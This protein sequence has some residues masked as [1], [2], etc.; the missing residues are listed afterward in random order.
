MLCIGLGIKISHIYFLLGLWK[1]SNL[2][3]QILTVMF[4]TYSHK[5]K[6]V[7]VDKRNQTCYAYEN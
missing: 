3:F 1:N 6:P 2:Y 7:F 4:V 5:K